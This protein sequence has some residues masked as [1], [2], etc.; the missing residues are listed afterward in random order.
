MRAVRPRLVACLVAAVALSGCAPLFDKPRVSVRRVD[1]T[2]VSFTG[3][4]ANIV[5]AVDNPNIIGLD[6]TRLWYQLTIDGHPFVQGSG[7]H[8]LHVPANG[9]GELQLPISVRFV[10]LAEALASLF[11]KRQV[12]FNIA[13]KL[14]FGTPLGV[15]DVPVG[16]AG[17]L[18]VPQ[19]PA[20]ALGPASVG[21]LGPSGADLSLTIQVHN[22]NTFPLPVGALHYGLS[23]NGVALVEASTPPQHLA[24]GATLPLV[25]GAHLDFVR[26]G[27]GIFR[28]LE[29]RAA[30]VA[31]DGS[32]DLLGYT[33]PV[34]LQTTL[35]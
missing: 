10:D 1:I 30:T 11:T 3:V 14:G 21:S 12:P 23:V 9:S 22:S 5:F 28:V 17:T 16:Y 34:H 19:L 4:G 35:R 29:S 13:T 27:Y 7:D 18:P 15:L 8:A 31:L 6:L 20:L 32:F 24:A 2:S 25:L 33:M 26:V